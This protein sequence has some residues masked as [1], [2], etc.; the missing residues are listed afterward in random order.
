VRLAPVRL[1]QAL[2]AVLLL[3]CVKLWMP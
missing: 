3:A 2:G 1:R